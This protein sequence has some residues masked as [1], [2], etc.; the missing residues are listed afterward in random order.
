MNTREMDPVF[1]SVTARGSDREC[2]AHPSP[3]PSLAVAPGYR[4]V[5]RDHRRR[6]WGRAGR[7]SLLPTRRAVG[8]P[9]RQYHRR[10][11]H[12]VRDY[13]YRTRAGHRDECFAHSDLLIGG[14]LRL[15]GRVEHDLLSPLVDRRWFRT[16]YGGHS[17]PTWPTHGDH[18]YRARTRRGD[19]KPYT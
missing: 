15:S 16:K 12:G 1:A 9:T 2:R 6:W 13:R 18:R 3:A 5:R 14:H 10:H 7:R 17:A 4:R 19:F 8:H 11:P